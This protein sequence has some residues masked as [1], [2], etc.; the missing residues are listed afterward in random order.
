MSDRWPK[1][2]LEALDVL[3]EGDVP[4][5]SPD[6]YDAVATAFAIR[7]ERHHTQIEDL[8]A[9]HPEASAQQLFDALSKASVSE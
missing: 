6:R 5:D 3:A 2:V 7:M 9:A 8:L 4:L 1:A